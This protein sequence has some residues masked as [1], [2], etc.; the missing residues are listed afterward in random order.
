[1]ACG[2]EVS[3]V[4]T[5]SPTNGNCNR[6]SVS[7]NSQSPDDVLQSP[8]RQRAIRAASLARVVRI[9]TGSAV[10]AQLQIFDRDGNDAGAPGKPAARWE[11]RVMLDYSAV[12]AD[13]LQV[14]RLIKE[15]DALPFIEEGAK[16]FRRKDELLR[17]PG[18]VC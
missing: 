2:D 10:A 11:C 17:A 16:V 18:R 12:C 13:R 9:E 15:P 8:A 5:A 14:A 7:A 6:E 1:M 3:D 4:C